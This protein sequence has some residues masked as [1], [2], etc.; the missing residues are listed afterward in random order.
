M[1]PKDFAMP[2]LVTNKKRNQITQKGTAKEVTVLV[3]ITKPQ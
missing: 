3:L 1:P 2:F